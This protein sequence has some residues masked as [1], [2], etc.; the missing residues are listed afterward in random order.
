MSP[1]PGA[2]GLL[3]GELPPISPEF[4][5][6]SPAYLGAFQDRW[7]LSVPRTTWRPLTLAGSPVL[8]RLRLTGGFCHAD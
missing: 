8:P 5:P 1:H 3:Q 4:S 6:F 7:G 2:D